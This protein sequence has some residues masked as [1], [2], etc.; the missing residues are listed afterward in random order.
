MATENPS[1]T[2]D[3]TTAERRRERPHWVLDDAV[4]SIAASVPEPDPYLHDLLAA[5]I[6]DCRALT[7]PARNVEPTVEVT[8][9]QGASSS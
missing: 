9:P 5:S 8:A 7:G 4:Y 1:Y 6:E 2:M 3:K